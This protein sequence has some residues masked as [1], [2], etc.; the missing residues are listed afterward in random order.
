MAEYSALDHGVRGRE[1]ERALVGGTEGSGITARLLEDARKVLRPGGWVAL[2]LDCTRAAACARHAGA[3]GWSEVTVLADLFGR[4]RY[5]LA[6][7][8]VAS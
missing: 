3:L 8:G 4:D 6:R 7:R 1:P 2:E 5:L